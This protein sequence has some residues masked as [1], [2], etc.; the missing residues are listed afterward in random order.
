MKTKIVSEIGINHNGDIDI[1]KKMIDVAHMAGIPYVKF[2]K[3]NPDICVPEDQKNKMRDTPWGYIT[4]LEYKKKIEFEKEEFDK[5]DNYCKDKLEWFASPWDVDSA[6]FLF[7]LY[8]DIPFI[9]IASACI[10][11]MNLLE[12]IKKHNHIPVI[13]STGM[14]DKKEIDNCVNYLGSQIEYMLAC[15]STY[16]TKDIDINLNFIKTLKDEYPMYKIGFSN[17]SAGIQFI[18]ASVVMG[19]EMVEFH[20]TLDRAM[21]GTDQGASIETTGVFRITKLIQAIEDGLG[22][23]DWIVTPEEEEIKKKLRRIL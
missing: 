19:A 4:Y 3:R 16:P 18:L 8:D 22:N 13:I 11:D 12:S 20:Q 21:Y 9:K 6:Y 14:S 2:Q 15:T 23:G 17:H 5:I 1:A 10:T 7:S